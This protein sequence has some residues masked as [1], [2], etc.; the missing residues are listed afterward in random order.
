ME[1]FAEVILPLPLPGSY[2][3]SIPKELEEKVVTGCRVSVPLG[4]RKSYTALVMS[5]HGNKPE[6]YRIKPIKELLDE[7][8]VVTEKQLRL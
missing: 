8:P 1:K 5:V 4:D 7:E 6:G 2:T 3:Y